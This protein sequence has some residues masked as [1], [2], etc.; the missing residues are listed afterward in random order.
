MG[1]SSLAGGAV[2]YQLGKADGQALARAEPNV[3]VVS[4]EGG[5]LPFGF[6]LPFGGEVSPELTEPQPYLGVRFEPINAELAEKEN[7]GVGQGAIIR[8]VIADS[9][10]ARAGLQVGDIITAVGGEAVD[11]EHTLRDRVLAHKPNDPIQV[12]VLRGDRRLEVDV[13]LGQTTGL[14]QEYHFRVPN[15]GQP[16]Y[17]GDPSNCLPR[18]EQG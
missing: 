8:E 10:A 14:S 5:N 13:T 3:A 9:P 17:F 4:P 7:L 2:G 15:D 1:A 18:G 12:S 11:A 6:S 16:F